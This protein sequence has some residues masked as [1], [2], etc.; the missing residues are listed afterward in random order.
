MRTRRSGIS[1]FASASAGPTGPLYVDDDA[2]PGGDGTSWETAFT[3]LQDALAAAPR[4]FGENGGVIWVAG[5]TYRPDQG[6]GITP[7][8]ICSSVRI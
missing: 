2:P 3:F 6:A 8:A 1:V 5:G 7:G 4:Y